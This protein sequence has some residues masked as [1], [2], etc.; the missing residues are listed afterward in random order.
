VDQAKAD[1]RAS[2]SDLKTLKIEAARTEAAARGKARELEAARIKG[3][4]ERI[5]VL[6][7]ELDALQHEAQVAAGAL[8]AAIDE[9]GLAD[10]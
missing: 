4:D 10:A 3:D 7:R 1:I 9:Q 2:G 8:K 6:G 5:H